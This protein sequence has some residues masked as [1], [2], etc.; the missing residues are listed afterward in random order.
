MSIV[1]VD[2]VAWIALGSR[3]DQLHLRARDVF[4]DLVRE[5]RRFVTSE[6]VLLELGNSLCSPTFRAD[7][8]QFIRDLRRSP[9][10]EIVPSSSGLFER[11]LDLYASRHDKDWGLVDC[12]SFVIMTERGISDAFTQ[13]RH[14][15]QAGFKNLL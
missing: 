6:F 8:V 13:D 15:E 12:T 11:G 3:G 1:F 5:R 14:F 2:T 9:T 10:I 7:T 4:R